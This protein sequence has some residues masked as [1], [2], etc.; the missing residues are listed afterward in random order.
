M[1]TMESRLADLERQ[2]QERRWR[3]RLD[4]EFKLRVDQRLEAASAE[5]RAAIATLAVISK[6]LDQWATIRK[7]LA[8]VGSGLLAAGSALGWGIHEIFP[9]GF[10]GSHGT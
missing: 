1:I 9:N 4:D 10:W 5:L 3:D 7:T 8:W 2:E 6:Q